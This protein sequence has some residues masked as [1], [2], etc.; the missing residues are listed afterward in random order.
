MK[1]SKL[2]FCLSLIIATLLAGCNLPG[3][4]A[5]TSQV[6]LLNT[7][8]AQTIQAQQTAIA[9]TAQAIISQETPTATLE[10]LPILTEIPEPT[11]APIPTATAT[12]KAQCDQAAFVSETIPDGTDFSPGQSFTKTWTLKNSGSCTWNANYDVVFVEGAAMGAPAAKPLTAETVSP[13]QSVQIS[14]DL[15]APIAAGSHRGEFK[16]RN[17]NGV[18]FGIGEKNSP[19]WAEIDVKG[20]LYDFTENYCKSGVTWTNGAGSLPC[21]GAKGD[22]E[23]WVR[24]IDNPILENGVEDNEP[25]L[26]IHPENVT[27]GWIRGTYPEIAITGGVYFKAIV[28]CYHDADCDVKFKLNAKVDGGAEQTLATWRE[29]QDKRFNRVQVDL[30]HLA[31]KNVQFI[32]L[33]D[34]NGSPANDRALWFGPRIEP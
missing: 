23:G 30:G 24:K 28:G 25:G 19:F 7:A 31:G 34:A 2:I 27:D 32:L 11:F 9:E 14:F 5:P 10:D 17:A 20:T 6:D 22:S 4:A 15:T 8:A 16:L 12:K 29:V 13:G 3:R 1:Q 33:V 26:Q 21:P 18:I